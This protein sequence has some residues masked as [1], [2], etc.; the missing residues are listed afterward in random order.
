MRIIKNFLDKAQN[1]VSEKDS[2]ADGAYASIV[3]FMCDY[4]LYTEKMENIPPIDQKG[5]FI[6]F[7]EY[8]AKIK[9]PINQ[10]N[11]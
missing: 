1:H 2:L 7:E 4:S 6:P 5:I 9:K 11:H 10:Y 8:M 3:S